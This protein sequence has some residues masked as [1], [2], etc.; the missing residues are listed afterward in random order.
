M[1]KHRRKLFIALAVAALGVA[2][3]LG[4][5]QP[6]AHRINP[7][8]AVKIRLGMTQEKLEA[9]FRAPP[10][11][12]STGHNGVPPQVLNLGRRPD[13]RREQWT[14]D[15]GGAVVYFDPVGKVADLTVWIAPGR[16]MTFLERVRKWSY[17]ATV[18]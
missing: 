2:V 10:G 17:W 4:W 12:Y 3:Y 18:W 6:G 1:K 13:L 16:T 5:P 14:S 15:E 7:Y 8:T 11:D 9:I